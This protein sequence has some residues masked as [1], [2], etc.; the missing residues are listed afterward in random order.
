[1]MLT[2]NNSKLKKSSLK[3]NAKIYTF[4]IPAYKTAA[5]KITCPFAKDCIKFCYAQKGAFIWSPAK[6]KHNQNYLNTKK[7]DFVD[8]IQDEINR[9]RKIT[10]VRI[11]SSGD[12]YSP[13]YLNKWV[14]IAKNNPN[15]IFYSYTKSI[16]LVNKINK[17][18]NFIFIYSHGSKV[19]F[20]INEK[21]DRHAKI[22]KNQDELLQA[23]Y[24][25]ASGDDLLALTPN[26]KV[27]LIF[28]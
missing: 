27:G 9:K 16:P 13:K 28:H 10:H 15:I 25:D 21:K 17:P 4:D 23:G 7:D 6:N 22:F 12:Y 5:G 1:M 26:K 20:M 2:N 18:S 11:H 3:H 19:D 8:V 14:T 24:I